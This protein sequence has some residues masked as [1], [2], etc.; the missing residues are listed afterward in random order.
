MGPNNIGI[1]SFGE[2][3]LLLEFMH[4]GIVQNGASLAEDIRIEFLRSTDDD[5]CQNYLKKV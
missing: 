2:M 1:G 4:N 3:I 5:V